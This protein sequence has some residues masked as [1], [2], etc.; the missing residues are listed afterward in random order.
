MSK[1]IPPHFAVGAR[2]RIVRAAFPELPSYK[3]CIGKAGVVQK[4]E[5]DAGAVVILM[6]DGSTRVC[7]HENLELIDLK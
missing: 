3:R 2:V 1:T 7:F 6:E 5:T 4:H